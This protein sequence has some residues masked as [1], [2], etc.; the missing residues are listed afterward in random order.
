MVES[1]GARQ[2]RVAILIGARHGVLSRSSVVTAF[3][4][5]DM[6]VLVT[7]MSGTGKSAVAA[8]LRG[9]GYAAFDADDD[10]FTSPAAGGTWAWR[11]GAIAHLLAGAGDGLIFFTGCSDEQAQFRWDLTVV[12]TVPE[13]VLVERLATRSSNSY[14]RG[15]GELDRILA[16]RATIEPLLIAAA[17]LVVDTRQPLAAVVA[18]IL[19]VIDHTGYRSARC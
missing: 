7:G 15:A 1:R 13:A 16:D 6:R 3:T 12:L 17:D 19:T 4:L 11:T 5:A 2:L 10:G 14:G 8:E 9:R 18:S